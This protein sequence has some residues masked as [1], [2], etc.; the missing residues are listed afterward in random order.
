MG[1]YIRVLGIADPNIHIDELI[2]GL[3]KDGLTAKFD[4]DPTESPNNWTVIGVANSDGEELMQIERNPVIKGEL[5]QDELQEFREDIKEYKPN[6]AVKWLDKY[7]DNI[8]VIY[9]FQLLNASMEDKNFE[10]VGS[11]KATI[12]N[13]LGG[14]L[15]ADNEGFSNENGYHI[16]WQFA[17]NV[18]GNWSMA[19]KNILGQW[20]NFI[21]DL[22]DKKQRE[23]F[24][25]GK[26]PKAATKLCR[27]E[28]QPPT[29]VLL[30]AGQDV[31]IF[32]CGS[33]SASVSAGQA[34]L[35]FCLLSFTFISLFV[36][37]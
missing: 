14:L 5:G 24:W 3:S 4:L 34:S 19:V 12:W 9:A 30:Q 20:T 35:S 1:Y 27:E 2:K 15:Q 11:I 29:K 16:L 33:L 8:K 13:R 26:V 10:I 32:G 23:E 37:G 28:K 25:A 6:S 7:F 18:T 17:D 22:G 36:S 31:V 21:M